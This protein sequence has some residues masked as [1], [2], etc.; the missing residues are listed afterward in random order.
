MAAALPSDLRYQRQE[1]QARRRRAKLRRPTTIEV[2][3]DRVVQVVSGKAVPVISAEAH[4]DSAKVL[5]TQGADLASSRAGQARQ[6]TPL[7]TELRPRKP[8]QT[9]S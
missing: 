4:S 2:A 3:V 8:R 5:E 1:D 7:S 9:V 6:R